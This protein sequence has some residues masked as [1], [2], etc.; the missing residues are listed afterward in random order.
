MAVTGNEL[1]PG[2]GKIVITGVV[3][4]DSDAEYGTDERCFINELLGIAA[5]EKL[6]VAR[7]RVEKGVTTALHRLH[8][9]EER[10]V[11]LRGRG[12]V[13]VGYKAA[14]EVGPLDVVVVPAETPQKITN[15]GDEDLVFLCLC[16][17][18][19]TQECY[20]DLEKGR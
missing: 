11:I 1:L 2:Q 8:G 19:F 4:Y 6:S 14:V 5:D 15:I 18:A 13:E 7:A 20:E 16:T 9:V 10:Y 17:P 3:K 12:S